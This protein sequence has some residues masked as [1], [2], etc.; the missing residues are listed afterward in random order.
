[1]CSKGW[2]G[3]SAVCNVCSQETGTKPR[4]ACTDR[5]CV[6]AIDPANMM[7]PA[8]G[9]APGAPQPHTTQSNPEFRNSSTR[10]ATNYVRATPRSTRPARDQGHGD[11]RRGLRRRR[12]PCAD[13]QRTRPRHDV[14]HGT[15]P[16]HQRTGSP[17]CAGLSRAPPRIVPRRHCCLLLFASVH[18][19]SPLTVLRSCHSS[20]L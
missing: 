20:Q 15:L 5:R 14:H 8:P 2:G 10:A 6:Q 1:M 13:S 3:G 16:R 9:D 7:L 19:S 4:D 12:P 18:S 17:E 11:S